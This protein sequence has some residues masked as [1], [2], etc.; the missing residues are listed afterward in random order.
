MEISRDRIA[1][2]C[3]RSPQSSR[4]FP[5]SACGGGSAGQADGPRVRVMDVTVGLDEGY[6][7]TM[8][9]RLGYQVCPLGRLSI[10]AVLD[11]ISVTVIQSVR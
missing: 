1:L 8:C 3:V 11:S 2:R 6:D 10:L 7:M 5:G 4:A 9:S